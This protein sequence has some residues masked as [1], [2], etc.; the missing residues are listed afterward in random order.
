MLSIN[1]AQFVRKLFSSLCAFV[2]LQ[3]CTMAAYHPQSKRN[4]KRFNSMLITDLRLYVVEHPKRLRPHFATAY[5][6]IQHR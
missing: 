6:P 4:D 5:V 1:W 2:L 3:K